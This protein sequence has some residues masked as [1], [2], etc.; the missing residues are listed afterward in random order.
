MAIFKR[1]RDFSELCEIIPNVVTLD[2]LD[3]AREYATDIAR[4]EG[5]LDPVEQAECWLE[6]APAMKLKP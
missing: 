4:A 2:A 5:S 3:E 6:D 1:P